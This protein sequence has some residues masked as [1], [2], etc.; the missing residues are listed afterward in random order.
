MKKVISLILTA[1][2]TMSVMALPALAAR[3]DS[4]I[5]ALM[6]DLEIMQGDEKGDMM[7]DKKVSR[8]EFAKIAIAAS[9][10]KNS[11]AL[12]L[13]QSPFK[14]VPYYTWY[15]P[16]VKAA[17]SAN[18]VV[19]YLDAT[20]RPDNTV[21]Y[22]EAA[23]IMLRVLGYN[24]GDFTDAYPYGQLSKAQSLDLLDDV[25]AGIGEEMTRYNVMR[26]VYNALG[27]YTTNNGVLAGSHNVNLTDNADV[28]A[29][30]NEDDSLGEDKVYTSI[31]TF[32]K[33]AYFN[34]D[35]A[36]VRG[37]LYVKNNKDLIA[38]VADD[39]QT[40]EGYKS[41]FVYSVLPDSSVVGYNNGS[42]EE[43]DIPDGTTVY[44]NQSRTSFA[45]TKNTLEMGDTLN[46]K[47]TKNGSVD[48][49]T[50]DSNNLKGPVKVTDDNWI[51]YLGA[52]E[53]SKVFRSGAESTA[54]AVS[55]NDIVYYSEPLNVIFA[56]TDKVTGVYEK[57]SPTKDSP[58]K[59]TIS[60]KEYSVESV[61]AFKDLSSGGAYKYG[62]TITALLGR[63]GAVAG[64]AGK[65]SVAGVNTKGGTSYGN[66]AGFVIDAGKKD[67][68]NAD[69][70]VYTSY[71]AKVA[72][73]DG[74]VT[75]YPTANDCKNL[76]CA[77]VRITF[78]DGKAIFSRSTSSLSG[79]VNAAKN[80]IGDKN[81][82]EDVKILDTAGT[83]TDD[84]PLYKR[85]YLQR[86]DGVTLSSTK[87]AYY[88]Q[89]TAGEIDNIILNDVTG[90]LYSYGIITKRDAMTGMY[91]IDIGG[92]QN[93]YMTNFRSSAT[94]PH[95]LVLSGGQL[96][97]LASIG[98]YS[99]SIT[100]LTTTSATIG[101]KTYLLSD[102]T[103]VYV[104]NGANTY[105]K[106]PVEEAIDTNYRMTA[107]YDKAE[108][109]GGRIRIIVAEK[110]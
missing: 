17:V 64:I 15:A 83:Y 76:I 77:V 82:A 55:V 96:T 97:K 20:F 53:G 38:A 10:K 42:F 75:E 3:S 31:G 106:I 56:Y 73:P 14:D 32:N 30:G 46:V 81:V 89:N 39:G 61:D 92:A 86:I 25:N 63:S 34:D 16:Y 11:V 21:T 74:T 69:N 29:T 50:Y 37:K 40:K 90:D 80:M 26:L 103:I 65:G 23:T 4:G 49:V 67:F 101:S 100:N 43:I 19:G 88:S 48:Y 47:Y 51:T 36:G 95:K 12:G 44:A 60:G 79:K 91:T 59:V 104:R 27:T 107:Y 66:S 2:L 35:W 85:I 78:K 94:G 6:R 62:D 18:Y 109:S 98:S 24:D 28:I 58:E 33:G 54:S 52:D 22:E 93:T 68:T 8:A 99:G 71:Y 45:A 105:L 1:A 84:T 7:L 13:K 5:E 102:D 70:T 57:A 72:Q 41:Y 108:S 9:P 110:K 87:V